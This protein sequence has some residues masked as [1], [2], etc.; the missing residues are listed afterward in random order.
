M[1]GNHPI[2]KYVDVGKA[3]FKCG[4]D[5]CV[6]RSLVVLIKS[7]INMYPAAC[8]P[9]RTIHIP[10]GLDRPQHVPFQAFR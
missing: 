9:T 4:Y 7:Y 2:K 8:R 3:A 5:H 1:Y 6:D 10:L